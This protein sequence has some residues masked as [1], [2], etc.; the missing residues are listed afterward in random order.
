MFCPKAKSS[1]ISEELG[2][3]IQLLPRHHE[4]HLEVHRER[5]REKKGREGGR[6]RGE[7]D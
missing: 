1:Y 6:V 4:H 7:R 3:C 5:E 2:Y